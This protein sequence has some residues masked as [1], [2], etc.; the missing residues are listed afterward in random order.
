VP[1]PPDPANIAAMAMQDLN[2]GIQWVISPINY[3]MGWIGQ[4]VSW[5]TSLPGRALSAIRPGGM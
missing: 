3:G 2:A 4:G 1:T 5:A